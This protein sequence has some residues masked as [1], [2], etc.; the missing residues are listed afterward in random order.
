LTVEKAK[1]E[2]STADATPPL[3]LVHLFI[4]KDSKSFAPH[5][6]ILEDLQTRFHASVDS[7]KVRGEILQLGAD[8]VGSPLPSASLRVNG[9]RILIGC[10]LFIRKDLLDKLADGGFRAPRQDRGY[11]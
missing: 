5:L 1:R 7:G 11:L 9:I 4:P 10:S 3:V 2:F 6:F 8:C